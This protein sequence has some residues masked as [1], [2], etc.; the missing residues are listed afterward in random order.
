MARRRRRVV[1]RPG[2]ADRV[3]VWH[4]LGAIAAPAVPILAVLYGYLS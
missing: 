1:A 3:T 4:V 2:T